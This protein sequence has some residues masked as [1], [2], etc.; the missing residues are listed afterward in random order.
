[1]S[2][3][4]FFSRWSRRKRDAAQDVKAVEAES[5]AP[6]AA[7][8]PETPPPTMDDVAKLDRD[9]DFARFMRRDVDEAVKRSAMKKLFSDPHFNVMDG[10]DIYIDDYNK[11]EPLPAAML[12]LLEHAKPV[13]N[14]PGLRDKDDE[15]AALPHPEAGD[16]AEAAAPNP[17]HELPGAPAPTEQAGAAPNEAADAAPPTFASSDDGNP[18]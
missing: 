5:A 12:A 17:D 11:F 8:Q 14:P 4:N 7:P 15:A 6:A 18:I 16:V 13:L 9:A 3:E 2:A 1:M 10:L